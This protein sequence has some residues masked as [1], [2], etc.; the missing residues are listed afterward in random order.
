[1]KRGILDIGNKI[2][3]VN[4]Q[5]NRGYH[6]VFLIF[7][8]IAAFKIAL[9]SRFLGAITEEQRRFLNKWESKIEQVFCSS[10]YPGKP[11]FYREK[12]DV[13]AEDM[14]IISD[15]TGI[16]RPMNWREFVEKLSRD[17]TF[18]ELVEGLRNDYSYIF[19]DS[20]DIR[21]R[22]R[23]KCR[24]SIF[25]LYLLDLL[26][27][28]ERKEHHRFAKDIFLKGICS[29][30][31]EE[32]NKDQYKSFYLFEKGDINA[33]CQRIKNGQPLVD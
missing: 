6:I 18:K 2:D 1:M 31:E 24:I 9:S 29:W 26:N 11:W 27:E 21:A 32:E 17:E 10:Q 14:L 23:S 5:E 16:L 4:P 30:Y 28:R 33:F 7:Q 15:K 13:L 12:I 8:F 3:S 22:Y 25:G 19:N 20:K